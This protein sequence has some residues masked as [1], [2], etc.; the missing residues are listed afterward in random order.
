MPSVALSSLGGAGWQFFDGNGDPLSGGKLYTYAAGTTT[1][2][3]SYTTDAGSTPNLNPIILD[4]AGRIP[5]QVWLEQA[6]LYKFVLT[7]ST[8]VSIWTKDNIPGIFA[9]AAIGA[10]S[11]EYDPP[12]AGALTS[13]YTV[14][15]KL[16]QCV[17]VKDFGAVG[18]GVTDDTAAIQ[19]AFDTNLSVLLPVGEYYVTDMM[20]MN[21]G[22]KLYGEGRTVSNFVIQT[23]FNLSAQ[24][25]LRAGTGEPGAEIYDVGF[26]FQQADQAVR[27]N[28]TQYPPAI[29]AVSTPRFIVDRVRMEGAWDGINATGNSGGAYMGFMEICALNK[30][31]EIDGSLDFVHGQTWHFWPFG[32]T[33]LTNLLTVYYDGDTT[34]THVGRCDGFAVDELASFSAQVIFTANMGGAIPAMI[35]SLSLD[36]DG[37]RLLVQ[38]G[39]VFVGNSYSTKTSSASD[40]TVHVTGNGI[41][42]LNNH[43]LASNLNGNE[44][45]AEGGALTVNGG[46][47]IYTNGTAQVCRVTAGTLTL[48]NITFRPPSNGGFSQPAVVQAAGQLSVNNCEWTVNATGSGFAVFYV[49]DQVGNRCANNNFN[50]WSYS[51][52]AGSNPDGVYAPNNRAANPLF[53]DNLNPPVKYRY[54]SGTSSALGVFSIAHGITSA[55]LKVLSVTAWYK[56]ASGEAVPAVVTSI[57]GVNVAVSGAGNTAKVR[58]VIQWTNYDD[59]TW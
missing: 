23:D 35:N 22:Q 57:D 43:A 4:A 39:R 50:G 15:D 19:A 54:L 13:G 38:G 55:Q 34:A 48:N 1:P 33:L 45:F 46:D 52:P 2:L 24:G 47:F 51:Y 7:S 12:F 18:D 11:I 30:G 40:P 9:S 21:S 41:C 27:A 56:G 25:V 6:T 53:F 10:D 5:Y 17:S 20:T 3:A 31:L 16:A 32:I 26:K 36:N 29:Y 42:V 14:A 58:V 8:D 37:A 44:L 49:S 28:V 59:V